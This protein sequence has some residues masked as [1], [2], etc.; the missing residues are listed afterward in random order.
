LLQMSQG[1]LDL[2]DAGSISPSLLM[3]LQEIWN[4]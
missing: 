3:Q 4:R 2:P 1:P